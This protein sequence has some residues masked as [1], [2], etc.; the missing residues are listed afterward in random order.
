MLTRPDH[1]SQIRRRR[2]RSLHRRT[3][4]GGI[5]GSNKKLFDTAGNLGEDLDVK[6]GFDGA[7]GVEPLR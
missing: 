1:R 6:L 2:Q 7:L 4:R 5:S 3:L